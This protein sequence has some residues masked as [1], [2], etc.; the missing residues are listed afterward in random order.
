MDD[1]IACD[2]G[3]IRLV[4][5]DEAVMV[6]CL[7][8][9][10]GGERVTGDDG[11]R[12]SLVEAATGWGLTGSLEKGTIE[13]DGRGKAPAACRGRRMSPIYCR[14]DGVCLRFRV[15]PDSDELRASMI[16]IGLII[17]S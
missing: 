3:V 2:N 14:P 11:L 1:N 13:S 7:D 10:G 12:V 15:G 17:P 4:E 16:L 8:G 9:N 6:D 5:D